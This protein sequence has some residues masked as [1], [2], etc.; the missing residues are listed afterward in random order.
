MDGV[1]LRMFETI[2]WHDSTEIPELHTEY[3]MGVP[4]EVSD[5]LLVMTPDGLDVS[6]YVSV[7]EES[8]KDD[9]WDNV[10]T[11]KARSKVTRWAKLS[12]DPTMPITMASKVLVEAYKT[13]EDF[14]SG[15]D[16]S[17]QSALNENRTV[18]M[19]LSETARRI[20]ERIFGIG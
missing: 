1:L 3:I 11:P 7:S 20:A 6:Q 17:I 19:T 14:R 12:T 13:D 15:F 9:W 18:A 8:V 16:A 2:E 5:H 4:F 10:R